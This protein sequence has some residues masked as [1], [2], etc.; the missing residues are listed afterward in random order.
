MKRNKR[1]TIVELKKK[2]NLW[3]KRSRKINPKRMKSLK[4]NKVN[5][6]KRRSLKYKLTLNH[7]RNRKKKHLRNKSKKSLKMSKLLT[8]KPSKQQKMRMLMIKMVNQKK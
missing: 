1:L 3:R 2:A 6:Q 8:L 5:I 4:H 7:R